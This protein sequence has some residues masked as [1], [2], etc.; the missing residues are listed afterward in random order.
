MK[1]QLRAVS[2]PN[3]AA[4]PL[5]A[6]MVGLGMRYSRLTAWCTR[7][8]RDQPLKATSPLGASMRRCM[9]EMSPPAQKPLPSPVNTNAFVPRSALTASSAW[10]NSAR[11][12]S[13]I[14][15]RFSGR[16]SVSV[17]TPPSNCSLMNS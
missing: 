3:P 10:I 5:T 7:C 14:A 1:S 2:A 4:A 13:L 17:A 8:C 12:A 9:P 15:L 11:M 16:F 6:A